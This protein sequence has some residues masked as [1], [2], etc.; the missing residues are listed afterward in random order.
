LVQIGKD[1]FEVVKML[2]N[3]RHFKILDRGVK[4]AQKKLFKGATEK[5]IRLTT[6]LDENSATCDWFG[7]YFKRGERKDWLDTYC[8][9]LKCRKIVSDES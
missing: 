8:H 1:S 3:R 6:I 4:K 2:S 7:E 5:T 9:I